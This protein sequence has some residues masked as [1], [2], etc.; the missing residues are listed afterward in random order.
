MRQGI[1]R[2]GSAAILFFAGIGASCQRDADCR[3]L[4][5]T[6]DQCVCSEDVDCG[7]NQVCLTLGSNTCEPAS[8]GDP[9]AA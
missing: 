6:R 2:Y 7:G 1:I 8:L 9:L 4:K 3:S 5:C